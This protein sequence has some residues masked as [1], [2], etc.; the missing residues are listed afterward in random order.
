MN[1]RIAD[2]YKN[3]ILVVS[4][5]FH[6]FCNSPWSKGYIFK[7]VKYPVSQSVSLSINPVN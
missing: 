5:N 2:Y 1:S 6:F 4:T 3:D 7:L